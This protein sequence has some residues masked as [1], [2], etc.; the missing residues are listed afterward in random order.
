LDAAAGKCFI[1]NNNH[2]YGGIR[3]NLVGREPAGKIHPGSEYENFIEQLSRDLLDIVNVESGKRI[4]NRVIRRTDLYRGEGTEHFPDLF[5]EWGTTE[6]VRSI[7]SDKIG[8][9]DKEDPYCRT[10]G[11]NPAGLFI[12]S[13]PN[14][15]PG[16]LNRQVSILDFAPTFCEA[17]GVRFDGFDGTAIPEIS[18]PLKMRFVPTNA[19]VA[20]APTFTQKGASQ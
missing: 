11:H 19:S 15:A 3:V 7:R 12:A 8:R 2:T 6:P 20:T 16:R 17:L 4:V 5:V 18:R 10:G 14:I 13:G 1:I 9:F